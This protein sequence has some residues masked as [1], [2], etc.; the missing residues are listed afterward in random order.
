M[1]GASIVRRY[2]NPPVRTCYKHNH[3]YQTECPACVA[4][5]K[6]NQK[7]DSD[8]KRL[9]FYKELAAKAKRLLES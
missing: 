6:E 7:E 2:R 9:K 4:S 1:L 3:T 5:Y 8:D